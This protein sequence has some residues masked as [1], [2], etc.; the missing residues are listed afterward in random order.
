[1]DAASP[2]FAR[3]WQLYFKQRGGVG[4][5]L[6]PEV[7]PVVIMD[8]N[9]LGPYVVFRPWFAGLSVAGVAGQ[10]SALLIQ[11]SDGGQS[12]GGVVGTQTVKSMVVVDRV[13]FVSSDGAAAAIDVK[14]R[15]SD[16][17]TE[18]ITIGAL[19]ADDASGDPTGLLG[20]GPRVGNV[21]IGGR[22]AA[23]IL[24]GQL[25]PVRSVQQH[26]LLGP[27]CL[28]P[29]QVLVICQEVNVGVI[30]GLAQGRYY[31]GA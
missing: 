16:T 23:S 12:G 5:T 28:Q 9:S 25:Y 26:I 13:S 19:Q 30:A 15:I 24:G 2:E 21:Q 20:G 18:A 17:N 31:G 10:R 3:A 22:N 29:Q 7:V 8:D 4:P 11:N 1:M 27:W 14:I 6:P